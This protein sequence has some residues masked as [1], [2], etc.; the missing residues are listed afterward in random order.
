M[1]R[2]SADKKPLKAPPEVKRLTAIRERF[3]RERPSL[4]S[5][6]ASG[7]YDVLPQGEYFALM[8]AVSELKEIRQQ[9]KLSLAALSKRS[10]IDK[11][12]LSRLENGQN[13]NPTYTTLAAIARAL[14]A[15]LQIVVKEAK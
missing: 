11:A 6:L 15:E 14:G 13:S 8:R 10:G 5:L 1:V 9:K 7:Q 2:K 12:A 4:E 3:Q